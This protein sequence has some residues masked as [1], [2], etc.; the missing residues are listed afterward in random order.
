LNVTPATRGHRDRVYSFSG[1]DLPRAV[2]T[3]RAKASFYNGAGQLIKDVTFW[4]DGVILSPGSAAAFNGQVR[5]WPGYLENIATLIAG[6]QKIEQ[7]YS[8]PEGAQYRV[9]LVEAHYTPSE[10]DVLLKPKQKE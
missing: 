9:E 4:L 1:N 10:Y 8:V 6:P 5:P 2:Q 7:V 3:L